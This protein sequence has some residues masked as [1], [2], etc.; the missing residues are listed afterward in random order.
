[1]ALFRTPPPSTSAA[2]LENEDEG[3]GDESIAGP[4]LRRGQRQ[5]RQRVL[6]TPTTSPQNSRG[7]GGEVRADT[8]VTAVRRSPRLQLRTTTVEGGENVNVGAERGDVEAGASGPR[9]ENVA[10][11]FF[12]PP[13]AP[14]RGRRGRG[15]GGGQVSPEV[16]AGQR[17][18][19]PQAV[20]NEEE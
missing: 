12:T 9:H 3:G 11:D 5:R 1:M 8:T 7:R 10:A 14:Q 18:G 20:G 15:R 16:V 2:L 19:T 4:G 6:F 17:G 13:S